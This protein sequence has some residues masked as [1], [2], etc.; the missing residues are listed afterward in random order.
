MVSLGLLNDSGIYHNNKRETLYHVE[1]KRIL[2]QVRRWRNNYLL[3]PL[4][5]SDRAV[6]LLKVGVGNYQWPLHARRS[7]VEPATTP[8]SIWHKR[9]GHPNFPSLKTY[10]NHLNIPYTDDFIGYIRDSCLRAK[11][12][13]TYC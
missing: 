13:K 11:A 6:H 12:T 10:L 4:N 5:L 2:A 1:S 9:L 8:L 7:V 3:K